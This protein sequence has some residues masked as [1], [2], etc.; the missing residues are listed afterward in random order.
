MYLAGG[1]AA[2]I[3]LLAF[4]LLEEPYNLVYEDPPLDVVEIKG[5]VIEPVI[6]TTSN[7][8][9]NPTEHTDADIG[10]P[11]DENRMEEEEMYNNDDVIIDINV[12]VNSGLVHTSPDVLQ[13]EKELDD[14]ENHIIYISTPYGS[15]ASAFSDMTMKKHRPFDVLKNK[16]LSLTHSSSSDK[17]EKDKEEDRE[18]KFVIN[19]FYK[20]FVY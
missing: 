15:T 7:D 9:E 12:D 1:L 5:S 20:V 6:P 11:S 14:M 10:I 3:L 18:E 8:L 16:I 2:P 13:H 19:N 17:E 4:P